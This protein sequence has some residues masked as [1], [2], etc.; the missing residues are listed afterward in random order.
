MEDRIFLVE[1]HDHAEAKQA[2][3][4][5]FAMFNF[6]IQC[7][8]LLPKDIAGTNGIP[9]HTVSDHKGEHIINLIDVGAQISQ[10]S[11]LSVF[12]LCA[13][14]GLV[15]AFRTTQTHRNAYMSFRVEWS[16]ARTDITSLSAAALGV[17]CTACGWA[18]S[19]QYRDIVWLSRLIH[20]ML[21]RLL[22]TD[23]AQQIV[24][25]IAKCIPETSCR[26]CSLRFYLEARLALPTML[27]TLLRFAPVRTFELPWVVITD[28][29]SH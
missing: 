3:E 11:A 24:H 29:T 8:W 21:S 22:S 14:V 28:V 5:T 26:F 2:L 13:S 12:E 18:R 16:D 9:Q 7:Y 20:L 1:F 23:L 25:S 10:V 4:T 6:P 19:D 15:K 17:S 27:S